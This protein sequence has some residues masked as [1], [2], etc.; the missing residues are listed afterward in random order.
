MSLEDI[1]KLKEKVKKDPNSKFFV[2]LAEEYR[3]NGMLDEAVSVLM[4][5]LTSQPG[6][7]S[8][9]V[10]LGKIYLEKKMAGAAKEEF[11]K[12]ISAIPDNLFAHKKLAEIYRDS[13]EKERAVGEYKVVLKLN[14]FDDDAVANLDALQSAQTSEETA[15]VP[16]SAPEEFSVQGNEAVEPSTQTAVKPSAELPG[17]ETIKAEEVEVLPSE[18]P[19]QPASEDAFEKFKRSI[20]GQ[21]AGG[22]DTQTEDVFGEEV[23]SDEDIE[24]AEKEAMSYAAAFGEN[25]ATPFPSPV[26][27]YMEEK[28]PA[29]ERL[30]EK[31]VCRGTGREDKG[32]YSLKDAE[33]LIAGG[34]YLKAMSIYRGM[35]SANPQNKH[36]MQKVEELRMLLKMLGK[37]KEAVID[38]LETFG[39]RI[40]EKR[41]EFFRSS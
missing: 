11:E 5:G 35:L 25:D 15:A 28:P 18:E 6:Y 16:E 22:E 12:V 19:E 33:L 14:P 2:P 9:R 21:S 13:G 37:D 39:G 8:A 31:P 24:E 20:A 10:S 38:K 1:K 29:A 17:E 40:K 36:I 7:T 26:E 3:K 4:T 41:D 27:I 34:N 32:A 30:P 23:I